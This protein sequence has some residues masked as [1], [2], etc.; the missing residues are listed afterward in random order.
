MPAGQSLLLKRPGPPPQVLIRPSVLQG[1]I[2]TRV[3][4]FEVLGPK[5]T[6]WPVFKEQLCRRTYLF[7]STKAHTWC[8]EVVEDKAQL[9]Q[10]F[11]KYK[12]FSACQR[13]MLQPLL[14]HPRT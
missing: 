2:D 12:L 9:L 8:Q 4:G 6:F 1:G 10:L 5:P 3:H 13:M 7:Y 11:N 14:T